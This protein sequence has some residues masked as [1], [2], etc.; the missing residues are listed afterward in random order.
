MNKE[1]FIYGLMLLFMVS[2]SSD[3][4]KNIDINKE[5]DL[6]KP[7]VE[8]VSPVKRRYSSQL[9]I[10]GTME[11]NQKVLLH[12]MESGFISSITKDIGDYVIKG[13]IISSLENPNLT[14]SFETSKAN[15]NLKKSLYDRIKNIYDETPD[16][17][18]VE[19]LEEAKAEYESAKAVY[20]ANNMRLHN[21]NVK[22]PF[23]GYIT[24]RFVDKGAL[25]QSGLTNTKVQAIVEIQDI[26][27]MRLVVDYPESDIELIEKGNE[28]KVIVPEL[29]DYEV[30][31]KINRVSN[32]LNPDTKTMRVEIDLSNINNLLKPGMYAKVSLTLKEHGALSVPIMAIS[33][34]KGKNFIYIIKD[35][36]V[37]KMNV[38]LGI[39]D[40]EYIEVIN[41]E[42]MHSD[43]VIVKGK[44]MISE[45][46]KVNV[47]KI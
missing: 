37:E 3:S 20:D 18:T 40:K 22:A 38:S 42:L 32:A 1:F 45:G 19:D 36:V 28:V 29:S 16:L 9:D 27:V 35:L 33:G 43:Q 44:E 12:S 34:K 6:N 15:Y 7:L 23:S 5:A 41:S 2:C 10:T 46:M 21:L 47:K 25:V 13:T 17:T 8:V 14:Q 31:G 26:S 4:S 24:K 11:A 30:N 39:E